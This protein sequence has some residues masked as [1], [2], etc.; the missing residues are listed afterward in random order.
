MLNES[1][2]PCG[3]LTQKHYHRFGVEI[4]VRLS[5]DTISSEVNILDNNY[6]QLLLQKVP[7]SNSQLTN[8]GDTKSLN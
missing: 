8:K 7:K 5:K 4:T 2:F 6:P 1:C 3:V